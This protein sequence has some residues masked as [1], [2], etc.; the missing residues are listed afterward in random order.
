[1]K[2]KDLWRREKPD[3]SEFTHYDRSS[4][5][6]SSIDR[7]YIDIKIASNNKI[8]HIMLSF[9]DHYNAILLT[10]SPQKLKLEKIHGTLI[11]L[12]YGSLSSPQLQRICFFIKNTKKQE[13][14]RI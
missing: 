3:F 5:T 14:I 6:R 9:T 11:T 13:S 10:D 4:G 8:N 12:Y 2:I 1:M 7:A